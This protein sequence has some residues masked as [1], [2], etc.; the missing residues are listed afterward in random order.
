VQRASF[1]WTSPLFGLQLF[2]LL[3]ISLCGVGQKTHAATF[4]IT[5]LGTLGGSY[6]LGYGI[7]NSGTVTG[8]TETSN[9]LTHAF[10]YRA[11]TMSDL[12]SFT[13]GQVY[14][15]GHGINNSNEVVGEAAAGGFYR[16]FLASG[17]NRTD[18]GGL[19]GDYSNAYGINDSTQ[20]VGESTLSPAQGG[21][22]HAF[23][24]TGST[25]ADI[26]TLGGNYSS[27]RSVNQF[28]HVV[29]EANTAANVT[30]AFFYNGTTMIDLG[31]FGGQESSASGINNSDTVV[32]YAVTAAGAAHAF[33]Y[34]NGSLSDLGTLGGVESAANAVNNKGQAVGYFTFS[35]GTSTNSH[36]FYYDGKTMS[37]LNDLLPPDSGWTELT[38]AEGISDLG[39]IAG[40]GQIGGQT[41]A[42]LITP[43]LTFQSPQLLPNGNF[44]ATADGLS[45]QTWDVYGSVD[46]T[47]WT[48]L[49]TV[50]MGPVSFTDT[51]TANLHY[52]FYR[53]VLTQ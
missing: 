53:G 37:D 9:T 28:G 49:R 45:G 47:N 27:A 39:Q 6:S 4:S 40:Y 46:L 22:T 52:R 24:R 17:T 50:T 16:A 7:N 34:S 12:S 48:S 13:V 21:Y 44:Q 19:G 10:I 3:L 35:T 20:I 26:G 43:S 42:F 51:N 29:G 36:A 25:M 11:G 32:G 33:V 14:S 18:L 8:E 41:H 2:A 30:H 15:S 23:L 1:N 38:S 5:D 31:T